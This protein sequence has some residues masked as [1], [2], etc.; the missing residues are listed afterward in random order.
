MRD[1]NA[2]FMHIH[3]SFVLFF[4]LFFLPLLP[5]LL[6]CLVIVLYYFVRSIKYI[7]SI[8]FL[9]L[10]YFIIKNSIN[11]I[12]IYKASIVICFMNDCNRTK[13]GG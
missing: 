11:I 7:L 10:L 8:V 3:N 1:E 6:C 12:F 5:L 9:L 2:Y 13:S 4:V